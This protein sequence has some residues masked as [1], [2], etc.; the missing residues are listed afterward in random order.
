MNI[1]FQHTRLGVA[2]KDGSKLKLSNYKL[3]NN[4]YDLAVF[5]KKREYDSSLLNISNPFSV[6][7][8]ASVGFTDSISSR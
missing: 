1:D 2:V 8:G 6:L 5:N 7:I 3:L 4:E